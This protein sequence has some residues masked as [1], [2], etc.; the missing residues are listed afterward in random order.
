VVAD[1]LAQAVAAAKGADAAVVVVGSMP[2][3]QGRENKDRTT[4]ALAE[5]QQA[6][7]EAVRAANPRTIVVLE[8]SY[9]DTI[10]WAQQHVPGILWTTHA[11]AE[12]GNAVADVLFG[13]RNP[14]GRLTQTWY[15]SDAELPDPLDYDIVKAGWTYQYHD[16]TPLYPFGHGL[17]YT[18]FRYSNLR[19]PAAVDRRG[20]VTVSVDVTNTGRRAG[21]EVVQLYTHQRTSRVEQPAKQ[22]R[23]FERVHLAPG[24]TATVRLSFPASAL[25]HWDVTQG[26]PVVE[27]STYDLMAG[28]SSADVR[29]RGAFRVAGETIP[30][31]DL[32]RPTRAENFDDYAGARLVDESTARGT[33]VGS[34]AAGQ[35]IAFDDV[36]LPGRRA[37]FTAD[38]ARAAAGNGTVEV[39][40]GSPT[41]R[42]LGT[43][44]VPSTG[45]VYRYTRIRAPLAAAGGRQPVHLVLGEGVRI[46]A[47]TVR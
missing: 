12:T 46:S 10:T 45:D 29:A 6:L 44:T 5:G 1:G 22:L 7:V 28:S 27:S 14:A 26:R 32:S 13:D 31:R 39:R 34:S 18:S 33:A 25:A 9:P 21:D 41:G 35:W 11:G 37:T 43:A 30:A 47:F 23:A 3:I 38:V 20:T 4:T 24:R 36:R 40:L 19:A 16:G 42:L 8:T 17:S 2:F 15:R